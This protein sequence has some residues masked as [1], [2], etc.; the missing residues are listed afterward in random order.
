MP[1]APP[2]HDSRQETPHDEDSNVVPPTYS[3]DQQL[4]EYVDHCLRKVDDVFADLTD[5]R[6]EEPVAAS[7]GARHRGAPVGE[8]LVIGLVHLQLH[9]AQIRTFLATRGVPWAG[10]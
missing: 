7:H 8:M 5:D 10:E 2:Q 6:A 4:L 3:R 1:N 9:A